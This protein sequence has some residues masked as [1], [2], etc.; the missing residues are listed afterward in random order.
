MDEVFKINFDYFQDCSRFFYHS[1]RFLDED[2][3]FLINISKFLIKLFP[4]K[5]VSYVRDKVN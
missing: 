1:L 2:L 5:F 4:K 3:S